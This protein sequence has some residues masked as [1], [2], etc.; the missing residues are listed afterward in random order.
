LEQKNIDLENMNKELQSFAYISSHD[1]QEPLRKIQ[2][3]ATLIV[4]KESQNLS[5]NGKDK[6]RK[7]QNAAQRMQ[8]LIND[9]LTYS[10]TNTN[11]RK[12]EKTDLSLIINEVNED[13]KEELEQKNA[14]IES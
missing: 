14:R 12:F 7:M 10:R 13:L 1:L 8:T 11:E 4:E 5:E 2:T 3:F 9:L 6:F